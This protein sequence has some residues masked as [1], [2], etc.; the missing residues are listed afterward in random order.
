MGYI[1]QTDEVSLAEQAKYRAN[2]LRDGFEQALSLSIAT[3]G[4]PNPDHKWNGRYDHLKARA[5]DY[6]NDIVLATSGA[7]L[8]AGL[9]GWLTMPLA[10]VGT[11]Y[12]VFANNTPAAI[13][14]QVP[15]NQVW[16]FYKYCIPYATT[17]PVTYLIFTKGQ[18]GQFRLDEFD[19]EPPY[20]KLSTD[21]FFS[22]PVVY[23]KTEYAGATVRARIVSA[24][25]AFVLQGWVI[26]P[27]A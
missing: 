17:F 4:D 23:D 6:V 5:F 10:A 16:I 26:E 27:R 12:S 7:A 19:L 3:P 25:I 14:P 2:A 18:A 20:A 21:G 22:D 11:A 24:A 9:A 13:F 8:A 1:I 15:N